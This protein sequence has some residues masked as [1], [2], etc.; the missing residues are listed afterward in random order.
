MRAGRVNSG[1]SSKFNRAGLFARARKHIFVSGAVPS[2]FARYS[3]ELRRSTWSRNW[4]VARVISA[5]TLCQHEHALSQI[6]NGIRVSF[7]S[8]WK[9]YGAPVPSRLY[10][11]VCRLVLRPGGGPDWSCSAWSTIA[12]FGFTHAPRGSTAGR[13]VC[14]RRGC[15]DHKSGA[16]SRIGGRIRAAQVI[17]AA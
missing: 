17:R 7:G 13:D 11:A 3:G 15:D 14:S 5:F 4:R 12:S 6:N 10:A 16:C 2:Q 1:H 8:R 9:A